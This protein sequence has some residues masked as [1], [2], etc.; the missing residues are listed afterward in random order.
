LTVTTQQVGQS[1]VGDLIRLPN[2]EYAIFTGDVDQWGTPIVQVVPTQA[3]S[4]PANEVVT[5]VQAG[6]T[7]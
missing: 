4:V 7:S 3:R 2:G 1:N 6:P 5:L